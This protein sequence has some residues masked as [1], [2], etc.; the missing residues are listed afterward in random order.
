MRTREV[1]ME[2]CR[3]ISTEDIK[4]IREG[5][6]LPTL[7]YLDFTYLDL[8]FF[9]EGCLPS[10]IAEQLNIARSAVTVKLNRL[11][12]DGWV[13]KVRDNNDHR[14]YRIY[15]TEQT[16]GVYQPLFQ[17]LETMEG[18]ISR[19]FTSDEVELFN[20]MLLVAIGYESKSD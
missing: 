14:A 13:T 17:M 8:V 1:F 5:G 4:T 18:R 9:N 6:G 12:T 20:R 3:Y 7:S 19:S 11:E 15:L 16:K 10:F 2:V